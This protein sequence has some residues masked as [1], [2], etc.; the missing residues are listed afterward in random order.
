MLH[1]QPRVDLHEVVFAVHRVDQELDGAGVV[2]ADTL[3]KVN[4]IAKNAVSN[5]NIEKVTKRS[6]SNN[7]FPSLRNTFYVMVR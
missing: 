3:A 5:L 2:V 4:C 6:C 7:S 1:L